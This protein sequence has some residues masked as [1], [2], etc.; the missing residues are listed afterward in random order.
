MI[1]HRKWCVL[2]FYAI[3]MQA[4]NWELHLSLVIKEVV[5]NSHLWEGVVLHKIISESIKNVPIY[6]CLRSQS[7]HSTTL[8]TGWKVP[9]SSD[10]ITYHPTTYFDFCGNLL[11][12]YLHL[13]RLF[14]S[15]QKTMNRGKLVFN[16]SNYVTVL[17]RTNPHML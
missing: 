3:L 14:V 5:I 12:V 4:C 9:I 11:H 10:I 7:V 17:Q 8:K 1:S 2:Y 15:P 16:F 6:I 13:H